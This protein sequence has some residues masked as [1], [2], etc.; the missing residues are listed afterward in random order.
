[1]SSILEKLAIISK[2]WQLSKIYTKITLKISM[3]KR[4]E[5]KIIKQ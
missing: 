5:L 1:M 3:T 2:R 4:L